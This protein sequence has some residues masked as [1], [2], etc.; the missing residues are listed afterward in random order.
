MRSAHGDEVGQHVPPLS[1]RFQNFG[2]CAPRTPRLMSAW[3]R[4][5]LATSAA[6]LRRLLIANR[7]EIALRIARAA[8]EIDLHAVVLASPAD[9]T[10]LHAV[11]GDL[12]THEVM[13][14]ASYNDVDAVVG[15]A[16]DAKCDAIHP[17]YGFLSESAALAE[18][19]VRGYR[20][21]AGVDSDAS[22]SICASVAS[23]PA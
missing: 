3:W 14:V 9:Q 6:P 5:G 1:R 23:V 21:R 22:G 10:A 8:H 7:G 17:G 19:C 15:A 20:T 4:R 13:Q 16:L 12:Q 11:T 18:R 2:V